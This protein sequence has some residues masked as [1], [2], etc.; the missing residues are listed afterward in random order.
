MTNPSKRQRSA[1][2]PPTAKKRRQEAKRRARARR[3]RWIGGT[4]ALAAVAA[5]AALVVA[6]DEGT[7]ASPGAK[8]GQKAP[9]GTFTSPTGVERTI[10][11]LKGQPTL[12]WFVSTWCTSCQA[13]TQ[14]M[15]TQIQKFSDMHIRVV[16]LELADDLGQPGP[17]IT[18]FAHQLAGPTAANP[19][20][21]FGIASTPLTAAYDPASDLDIYYLID[22]TGHVAY[23]DSS[24]AATMSELLSHASSLT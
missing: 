21:T 10:S 14:A 5:I 8:I 12:L 2:G 3:R 1:A 6:A 22:S 7:S 16:E 20:W 24:P 19:D 18:A 17:T 11:S 15:A 23:V 9:N 13:G 4:T